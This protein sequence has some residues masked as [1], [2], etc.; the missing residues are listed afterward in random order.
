MISLGL[1]MVLRRTTI[2]LLLAV[3]SL[4]SIA[5]MVDDPLASFSPGQ[6]LYYAYDPSY[7]R[8]DYQWYLKNTG[9]PSPL[10]HNGVLSSTDPG[11][12]YDIGA[13]SAWQIRTE[14]TALLALVDTGIATNHPD[15]IHN[16]ING[17]NFS[18]L[19]DTNPD[20]IQDTLG[21]GTFM[22]GIIAATGNN[23]IGV[24]GVCW[25]ANLLICKTRLTY[26]GAGY[27][28][29]VAALDYAISNQAKIVYLPWGGAHTPELSNAMVRVQNAGILAILAPPNNAANLDVSPDYPASYKLPNTI[30]VTSMTRDYSLY[31]GAYGKTTVHLGAPGRVIG[32]TTMNQSYPYAYDSGTSSSA[33]V[34]AGAAALIWSEYPNQDW[35]SIKQRILSTVQPAP[36]LAVRTITGG[37]LQLGSA[38]Q[39]E[40]IRLTTDG[41]GIVAGG[42]KPESIYEVLHS[43]N[44]NDWL[45]E[46]EFRAESESKPLTV[47]KD[48]FYRIR[49]K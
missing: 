48:G 42:L 9:Q 45:V 37:V 7:W 36:I 21:H 4:Q 43:D 44:L 13:E 19:G 8:E 12:T 16:N 31:T 27:D 49:L 18:L 6:L 17:R 38:I 30:T 15:L 14:A 2:M 3:G 23:T 11:G 33:A 46:S 34:V 24:C 22:A 29:V 39:P 32:T 41:N 1:T 26:D 35:R 20:N 10:Y 28:E 5:T 47:L 25:K 40:Q